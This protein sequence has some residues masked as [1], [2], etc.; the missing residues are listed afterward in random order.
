MNFLEQAQSLV[1]R[2]IYVVPTYRGLRHPALA[3]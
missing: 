3:N 2:E 1:E